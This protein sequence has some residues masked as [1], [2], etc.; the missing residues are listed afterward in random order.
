MDNA[1][2]LKYKANDTKGRPFFEGGAWTFL[3]VGGDKVY[4]KVTAEEAAKCRAGQWFEA[5]HLIAASTTG[6]GMLMAP[7]LGTLDPEYLNGALVAGIT[8]VHPELGARLDAKVKSTY[9]TIVTA[10]ATDIP[11]SGKLHLA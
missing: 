3:S 1:E 11:V 4:A 2:E 7:I 6:Q 9:S 10:K 5:H 8:F